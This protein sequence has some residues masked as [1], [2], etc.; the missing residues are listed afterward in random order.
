MRSADVRRL[1]AD[2]ISHL[3]SGSAAVVLFHEPTYDSAV[4]SLDPNGITMEETND[5]P[6][7]IIY[8]VAQAEDGELE[9]ELDG[10]ARQRL[11][12]ASEVRVPRNS[13]YVLRNNSRSVPVL[14]L[15]VVPRPLT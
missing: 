1:L 15:A 8:F 11:S 13:R 7:D 5:G 12:Q 10:E 4:I 2:P 14:L 3:G 9:L 6:L